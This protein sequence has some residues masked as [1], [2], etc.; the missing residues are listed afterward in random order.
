[1]RHAQAANRRPRAQVAC[2]RGGAQGLRHSGKDC[3][4]LG[5]GRKYTRR[6]R[7][8]PASAGDVVSKA[9]GAQAQ[10]RWLPPVTCQCRFVVP[11]L[12]AGP[13][14]RAG[15]DGR[16]PLQLMGSRP[17][18]SSCLARQQQ[19]EACVRRKR[20]ARA[21][22][23][24]APRDGAARSGQPGRAGLSVLS[25]QRKVRSHMNRQTASLACVCCI[26]PAKCCTLVWLQLNI[27]WHMLL[28]LSF[29]CPRC[30]SNVRIGEEAKDEGR[31]GWR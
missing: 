19:G 10:T 22:A 21:A 29:D 13:A 25:G 7:T 27:M 1:M 18:S 11:L 3:G 20:S 8:L 28:L 30:P 14:M 17:S 9:P 12:L 24:A 15:A 2:Q 4:L 31:P 5:S 16:S 23:P 6:V 26:A